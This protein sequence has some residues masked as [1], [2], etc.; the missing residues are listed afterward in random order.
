M[1][2]K[3]KAFYFFVFASDFSH[4]FGAKTC[5]RRGKMKENVVYDALFQ[6]LIFPNRPYRNL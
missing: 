3:M 2:K 5:F 4:I 6:G 1:V